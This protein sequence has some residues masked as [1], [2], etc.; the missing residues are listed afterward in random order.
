MSQPILGI[1]VAKLKF[2]VCLIRADGRLKHRVFANT[3]VGFSELSEWLKKNQV[4]Q[5]HACLEA[6]NTYSEALATYLSDSGHQVS[7]V[8]PAATKAYSGA[9]LARTKTD[10]VDAELIARFCLTQKPPLWAP[11]APEVRQLQALVRRLDSLIEMH[12]MEANRLSSGVSTTEVRDS[13]K[14][15]ISHLEEQIK[16]TEKLIRKHINNHPQLRSDRDL[17]VSIP[18]LGEATVARLMS[19]INFHR[20]ENARQVA[21]FAGL[22][23][24]LHESGKSVRGRARLSKMGTPR[25]RRSLYFPAVTALRCNPVIKEWASGLRQR[26][27]CE[28]QI[29]GAVM[30]KLIHLAFGVLKSGKPYDPLHS[31]NA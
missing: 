28:M 6:T 11:A 29:I 4:S 3:Q 7:L 16:R 21:A 18:G 1:D 10:K 14:S 13:I 9:Q 30:R 19:E 15:L 5:V 24:R 27:K 17:L 31:Q 22:V 8:N 25:I 20:Y 2:N 23:P 26:G 12:T